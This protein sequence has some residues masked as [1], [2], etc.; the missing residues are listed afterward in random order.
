MEAIMKD[1]YIS[2]ASITKVVGAFLFNNTG[3]LV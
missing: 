2:E 1:T 3:Y